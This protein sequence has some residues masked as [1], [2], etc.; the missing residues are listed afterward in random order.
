M[1]WWTATGLPAA[2]LT[3]RQGAYG[4]AMPARTAVTRKSAPLG[5]GRAVGLVPALLEEPAPRLGPQ[6]PA[7]RQVGLGGASAASQAARVTEWMT[8]V[9]PGASRLPI[10]LEELGALAA[11]HPLDDAAQHDGPQA[12]RG[13]GAQV[14]GH[15]L[16][17]QVQRRRARPR[18]RRWERGSTP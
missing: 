9:P 6:R 12:G 15:G 8:R 2:A 16:S 13:H 17:A 1:N 14:L 18:R 7:R 11:A 5:P 4:A 10:A 3:A